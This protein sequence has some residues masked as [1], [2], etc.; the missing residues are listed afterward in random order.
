MS[1]VLIGALVLWTQALP[2]GQESCAVCHGEAGASEQ[3]AVHA[4]A[5][6]GCVDCHGGTAGVLELPAAH[7]ALVRV[8]R[9]PRATV[10]L[11][12]GCHSDP[13]R[14]RGYGLRTDQLLSFWTSAHG[15]R[16]A[17]AD[18]EDVATCASCH[19][20]HGVLPATD[21][22]SP[23]HPFRQV[24]TCGRC[25]ADEVLMGRHALS[26]DQTRLFAASVHGRAL[27]EEGSLAAPSCT[28]CHGSHGATP[29][30]VDQVGRVCGRCHTAAEERFEQG[31]HL[32]AAREGLL[33]ECVS[34]HGS[35]AVDE[36]SVEMLTGGGPGHCGS[37]HERDPEATA[38]GDRLHSTLA[39]FDAQLRSTAER[40]ALAERRGILVEPESDRL[41]EARALR[42]RAGPLVHALSPQA[43]EDLLELG[44]GMLAETEE[45][46]EQRERELRD[47]R[48][49]VLVFL[50]ADLLLAAML[51]VHAREVAGRATGT[52]EGGGPRV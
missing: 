44:D 1:A 46:V 50:G 30:R 35:H 13:E 20:A 31:P 47:R 3:D 48:V 39:A 23:A 36:P 32:A 9:G 26:S 6:I 22:R 7:G 21:P 16:L 49:F 15:E 24:E 11:C 37:C 4:R 19:G 29:P 40:L 18:D 51:L 38:V 42:L 33:E 28:G 25:H 52:L 12:G 45:G 27:L 8:P 41:R 2:A 5:G 34:C 43:L 17:E 14:M 10:E